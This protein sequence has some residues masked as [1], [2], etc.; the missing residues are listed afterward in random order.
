LFRPGPMQNNMPLQFLQARHGEV[1]PDYIHE[2]FKP[3]LQE[4]MGVIVFHEQVMR[5]F[6]E[7]T[8]CGLGK[9][10][11]FRRRLENPD[12]LASTFARL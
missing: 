7:L 10:D 11:V 2:R 9:A 6:D 8:G 1:A 12:E 5:M 3:F 4:T